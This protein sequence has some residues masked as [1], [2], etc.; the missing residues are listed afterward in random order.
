MDHDTTT[1][2]NVKKIDLSSNQYYFNREL[3][4]IEFNTRVL[5]EAESKDHPLLE[6][7]KFISI[8]S[9]NLD[10]F[11]MI[12]VAGLKGQITAGVVELSFDG[13]TPQ[14]QLK[15]IRKRLLPLYARQERTLIEDI[16]PHMKREGIVIHYLDTLTKDEKKYCEGYFYDCVLPALTPLSLDPAHPFPKLVNRSLNIAFVLKDKSKKQ[17]DYKVSILQLPATLKRFVEIERPNGYHFVL[18]EQIIKTHADILFPGLEIITSNTFR[19]TRDADIEI[20]E[21]EAEDLLTE[22]E[23]QVKHRRWGTAA[24][25]LEASVNMPDYLLQLLTKS[26]EISSNDVYIHHRP[27]KLSDFM[28]LTGLDI[29]SLK[30]IPFQSRIPVSLLNDRENIFDTIKHKDILLHHPYDSFSNSVLK[31]I[32]I[33]SIDPDV[34]AIKITLYRTGMNSMVVEGLKRAAENGKDVTAFVELKARF[35]EE[36]N[37]SWAKELE[38]VG[39]H[40]VYG[41]MGLKT[42]CKIALVVRREN[43]KLKTYLHIATGNYNQSTSRIYTDLGLLTSNPDFAIEGIHLFNYLTGYSNQK[44]WKEFAVAPINLRQRIIHLID[45]ETELHTPENPGLIIAKLNAIAHDEVIPAL[46]RA[47]QKGVKIKLLVRG[48]CCLRP[49]VAG[50]S[51]NIEV[52]SILG[53]FLEHSRI[54]YFKNAGDEEFFLSSADWMTRNLHRRVELMFP[55]HEKSLQKKIWELLN[56]YWADNSKSWRL[57]PTGSYEKIKPAQGEAPFS[58]QEFLLSELKKSRKK[59]GHKNGH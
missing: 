40:V 29:R 51:E 37:I 35:D 27:L 28:Q 18:L 12:R 45:R 39:V 57:K 32:D 46:Y 14:D 17:N 20:A 33:A 52:R 44:D 4:W 26:L 42:H 58:A 56:I 21:D 24:V 23:E 11:F 15:E 25:R 50:V 5:A 19:I 2:P 54:F 7:L 41:V 1:N 36:N 47:S 30:D 31:F 53:R 49:G 43:A 22:I 3:S 13:M 16:I 55:V 38:Q 34:L 9:S 48:V 8:F 6:R 59:N 10:E